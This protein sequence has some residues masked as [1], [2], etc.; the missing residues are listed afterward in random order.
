MEVFSLLALVKMIDEQTLTGKFENQAR[1]L[2]LPFDLDIPVYLWVGARLGGGAVGMYNSVFQHSKFR[3]LGTK[4]PVFLP[5]EIKPKEFERHCFGLLKHSQV[6]GVNITTPYKILVAERA[7][8]FGITLD[9]MA[10]RVGVGS[11]LYK[12]K[13]KSKDSW[14]AGVPD[15]EGWCRAAEDLLSKDARLDTPMRRKRVTIFGVGGAGRAILEALDRPRRKPAS[16]TIVEHN[17]DRAT[18]TK[19]FLREIMPDVEAYVCNQE[20]KAYQAIKNSDV[21]INATE[22]GKSDRRTPLRNWRCIQPETLVFDLNWWP[23]PRT[24]FLNNA[25]RRGA[26]IFNGFRMAVNINTIIITKWL[27]FENDER[28]TRAIYQKMYGDTVKAG[29]QE[30]TD[31]G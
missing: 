5:L 22:L 17:R 9:R 14:F 13:S 11:Y 25:K 3:F 8:E 10:Q 31:V 12:E 7:V 4:R 27:G 21:L 23:N 15:G 26:F 2:D 16:I 19:K 20:S 30:V 18:A 24:P 29:F 28:I 6:F 1:S